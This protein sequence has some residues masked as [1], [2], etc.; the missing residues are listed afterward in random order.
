MKIAIYSG[1][2]PSTTFIERLINAVAS[3]GYTVY[4][5]GKIE[6]EIK[7]ESKNIKIF[8]TSSN[9]FYSAVILMLRAAK[10]LITKPKYFFKYFFGHTRQKRNITN[11]LNNCRLC[12]T[13]PTFF[14]FNGLK[15]LTNGFF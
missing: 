15:V 1:G 4:L 5:F 10:L 6:R 12:C 11:C 2:I 13:C 14:T 8:S 7:Y 9:R 3:N